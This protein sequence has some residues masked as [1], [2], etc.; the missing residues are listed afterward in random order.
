MEP[1]KSNMLQDLINMGFQEIYI[2]KAMLLTNENEKAIE[3]ILKFQDED[4]QNQ[5]NQ[6]IISSTKF[7]NENVKDQKEKEEWSDESDD[8]RYKMV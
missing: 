2:K 5:I 6:A 1:S 7:G 8:K 4:E 3:L